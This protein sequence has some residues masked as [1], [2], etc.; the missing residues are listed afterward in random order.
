MAIQVDLHA[1]TVR[2]DQRVWRMFP[3]RGYRFL[4]SFLEQ[5]VGFLDFPD[6]VLPGKPAEATDLIPRIARSQ[7]VRDAF[8]K[9]G[10]DFH[11]NTIKLSDHT[12]ARRTK[13]RA[14]LRQ[15]LLNL[16]VEA[17]GG[18]YVVL[19]EPIFRANIHVGR[20]RGEATH[21]YYAYRYGKTAI[22]AR[23]ITWLASVPENSV[24]VALSNSL[25][26]Q[27]P[28][29]LLEKN[30]YVEI[31]SLA[32]GSFVYGDRHASTIYNTESDFLDAD[33][34]FLGAISRL[35][36]AACRAVDEGKSTLDASDLVDVLLRT[37]PIEYT[38]TQAAD[39]HSAGFNRYVSGTVVSLVIAALTATFIGFGEKSSK[40]QLP[41]DINTFVVMNS[42]QGADPQC[43]ARVSKASAMV[44]SALGIDKTWSLCEAA[45]AAQRRA[46]LKSSATPVELQHSGKKP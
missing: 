23:H 7:A 26:H 42:A 27:H 31:F 40:G 29:S 28:F 41:S 22:P 33:A 12:S 18:D 13:Y 9:H 30:L 20:I 1:P 24:S 46:G 21:G 3:G 25:R 17:K 10:S 19:P 43:T 11:P 8:H 38:C 44:L 36:A 35:A 15:A 5:H 4:D 2:N 34:A 32:H 16:M 37:P 45:R 14:L 6:L 39:I